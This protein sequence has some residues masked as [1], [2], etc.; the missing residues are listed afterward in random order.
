MFQLQCKWTIINKENCM[1]KFI[2]LLSL[3]LN[4][5]CLAQGVTT[6]S[7]SGN[8]VDQDGEALPNA[9]IIAVHQPSGSRYGTA[10]DINGQFVIPYMRIGGPYSVTVSFIGFEDYIEED[11]VIR[12]GQ[13]YRLKVSLGEE[14]TELSEIKVIAVKSSTLNSDKS[15]SG[16]NVS[17]QKINNLPQINR[18]INDFTKLAPYSNTSDF[19]GFSGLGLRTSS[20]TIDGSS[21]NNAYG[22]GGS[23]A[24]VI[25]NAAG[26][27]PISLDA[28]SEIQINLSP[29]DVRQGGFT[30]ANVNAVTKS[31]DNNIKGSIYSF[32][33]N[34]GLL[35]T[36]VEDVELE[37]SEFNSTQYGLRLGGPIIKNKLFFFVNYERVT[38]STPASNFISSSGSATVDNVTRVLTSDINDLSQFLHNEYGYT[39]GGHQGFSLKNVSDK[40]LIKLNYNINEDHKLSVRYNH[41]DAES[42]QSPSNSTFFGA[43][44]RFD[45]PNGMTF[46]NSGWQRNIGIRS[47]IGELNSLFDNK[48]SNRLIIGYSSFPEDR[49]I[50]GKLFPSVDILKNGTTYLSFGSDMFANNNVVNQDIFQIQDEF[51]IYIPNHTITFGI[52]F[53][54]Y[55]FKNGF[56]PAWQG[57]FV[58]A[59]LED[60]YNST[61]TGTN[62][63]IGVSDGT[64][65]PSSYAR[66]YSG[67]ENRE[68]VF[69]EPEFSQTSFYLQDEYKITNNFKLTGGVR[70]DVT[71]FLNSPEKNPA[72]DTMFFQDPNGNLIQLDNSKFPETQLVVSPRLGF[73]WDVRGDRTFQ[74]RGGIGV[75]NGISP[76][77]PIGD[78]FLTNGIN[79]GELRAFGGGASTYQF[80]PDVEEYIPEFTGVRSQGDVNFVDDNFKMP[81]LLKTTLG[82]D[83]QLPFDLVGSFEMIYGK[84]LYDLL[85]TNANLDH[86]DARIDGV[87]DRFRFSN[88]RIN[89]PV[90]SSAYILG[91]STDGHQL[92][93]SV[94]IEKPF[95]NN[96]SA[97]LAYAYGSAKDRTTFGGSGTRSAWRALPI[98]GNTNNPQLAFSDA[99]QRH[100]IVGA[101]DYKFDYLNFGSSTI[102]LFFE[103]AQNGRF[104]Y[105]YSGLVFQD[106]NGDFITNDLIFVPENQSQI[107]LSDYQNS[108][109]A[110][111]T[112]DE[113]WRAIDNFIE[114]STY[115]STRR[116]KFA[117]RNGS[118]LPWFFQ[119]DLRF[120]QNFNFNLGGKNN[121]IQFSLDILNFT[122]L[123]NSDWGIR[124]RPSNTRPIQVIR[125][126]TGTS[127]RVV[128]EELKDEFQSDLSIN[129]RWRM[130]F[131][132]RYIFN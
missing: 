58:F 48:Y 95:R 45:N 21:F 42:D 90:V 118:I 106:A 62:T 57:S 2:L 122:N 101:V 68:I 87:D 54:Y 75:F 85:P 77:V 22:L 1:K 11:I 98:N 107:N 89:H 27:E 44:G 71:S 86:T 117:E 50:R 78:A 88:S 79:Q 10:S 112:A 8:V 30:G 47:V 23:G 26:S 41:L 99:D 4:S 39:T 61:P 7:L 129:S 102:S 111:V 127:H 28:L 81:K 15:G 60:F 114:N 32:F 73:N 94:Q 38:G 16:K 104:S 83:Y 49:S 130:Q 93:L 25:G 6:G 119:L 33:Q 3:V 51:N 29:Y 67:L 9:N 92:N 35:G 84:T 131:G 103:G 125:S 56:T 70:F 105:Q 17:S 91:N 46:E 115:L 69:A 5:L 13:E 31:G 65:T 63:P 108:S 74:V 80:S 120:L 37:N 96:W 97:S 110:T 82:M 52:N 19:A 36:K 18:S 121:T 72:L 109:G 126:R 40:F 14:A 55:K 123:I 43:G 20:V 116:G 100:R 66:R 128:P 124:K 64:G 53:Q 76:F 12:L 59:S 113:Q 24:L 34:D 132:I